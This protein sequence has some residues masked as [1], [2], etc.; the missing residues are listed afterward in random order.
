MSPILPYQLL[1]NGYST[2]VGS[3]VQLMGID[4]LLG[5][6]PVRSADIPKA[7]DHGSYA[8]LDVFDERSFTLSYLIAKPI[9][10]LEIVRY[11]LSNA[12]S[13]I[14]DPTMQLPLQFMLPGWASPRQIT[15][16]PRALAMPIDEWFAFNKLSP[17]ILMVAND[18][19][20]YDTVLQT[21]GPIGLPSPAAGFTFN[22]TPDFVFGSSTGGSAS[23]TNVGNFTSAFVAT[24][25]GPL[26]NPKIQNSAGQFVALNLSLNSTDVL[27]I[28][29]AA[30]TILLN[31]VSRLNAIVTGS[32]WFGIPAGN[33]S[34]SFSSLDSTSVAGTFLIM[35]RNAWGTL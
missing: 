25:N 8:G 7:R 33:S 11:N 5:S 4:G 12:Y 3:D 10:A 13:L 17:K 34:L 35:F 20:V 28:D 29:M 24:I 31:G 16:R 26:N 2:G 32:S 9:A 23:F 21:I 22:A 14:S 19:L 15:C 18:P 30:K 6:P 27:V 1:Y